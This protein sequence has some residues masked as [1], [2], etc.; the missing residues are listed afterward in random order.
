MYGRLKAL[1]FE[2]RFADVNSVRIHYVIGGHGPLMLFLHGFPQ[3]W[4]TMRHLLE[5]FSRDHTV[6][7]PDLRGYNLSSKPE[8][9]WEYGTW[10]N[11]EDT[12]ALVRHLGYDTYTHVG[13]D[14]GGVAGYALAIHYPEL[15]KELIILSTP[16]PGAFDRELH[17]NPEQM[18]ASQYMLFLRRRD[19]TAAL[20]TNDMALLGETISANYFSDEDRRAYLEAWK[21]PGGI[22]GMLGWYRREGLGPREEGTPARGNSTPEVP[23]LLIKTRSLVVHGFDDPYIRP[24]CFEN[25]EGYMP[26]LTL[27]GLKRARSLVAGRMPGHDYRTDTKFSELNGNVRAVPII[28]ATRPHRMSA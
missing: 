18:A 24:G 8:N 14:T 1:G 25:L 5:E 2:S 19:S 13:H 11:V 16:H 21:Q 26:N 27:H 7:A 12:K 10:P 4:Y 20:A 9:L 3:C 28:T 23:S 6:V 17:D 15:L 22:D